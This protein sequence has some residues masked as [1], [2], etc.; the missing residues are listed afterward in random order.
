MGNLKIY[1]AKYHTWRNGKYTGIA[2]F[3]DDPNVGEAFL[4]EGKTSEGENCFR[5][6]Q[7]D[8]W[9]LIGD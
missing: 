9:E 3:T 6:H 4:S 2:T 1:G 8:R 7:P 5:V